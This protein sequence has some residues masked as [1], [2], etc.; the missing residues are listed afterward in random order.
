MLAEAGVLFEEGV[1]EQR[2]P[3]ALRVLGLQVGYAGVGLL[4]L[5]LS[6]VEQEQVVPHLVHLA[7]VGVTV[8]QPQQ[9]LLRQ[10]QIVELVF[11]DDAGVE[12]SVGDD[13]IALDLL[14]FGEGY[15]CQVVLAGVRVVGVGGGVG[16][17][18]RRCARG[19]TVLQGLGD[20]CPIQVLGAVGGV[21]TAHQVDH[22]LV[23]PLPVVN[24]LALAP[25]LLELLLSLA[26]GRLVVEVPLGVLATGSRGGGGR[27]LRGA[28]ADGALALL[29]L[30]YLRFLCASLLFFLFLLQFVDD[31]VDGRQPFLFGHGCQLLQRVLQI[32]GVSVGHQFVEHL[33]AVRQFLVVRALF[34]Q[35]SDGF[36]IAALRVVVF[37]L[38]P[39]EIAELQQQHAFFNAAARGFLV[40]FLVGANGA[41]RV[42]LHEVDVAHGVV[43]LVQVVLVV[44]VGSHAPQLPDHLGTVAL[45]HHFRLCYAGV[46]VQLVGR[47]LCTHFSVGPV[48]LLFVA[49]RGL[50]LSQQEVFACLLRLPLLVSDDFPEVGQGLLVLSVLDVIV[51]IGGIPVAHAVV[52]YGVAAHVAND[53]LGVVEPAQ[54]RIALGQ[55]G[56]GQRILHGLRLVEPGHVAEGGGGL[57]EIAFLELCLA[58]QQPRLPQE[59]VVLLAPEPFPVAGRLPSAF[60]PLGAALDGVQLDGLLHLFHGQAELSFAYVAA[61]LV[62]NGVEGNHLGVV[63]LVALLFLQ[64]AFDESLRAVEVGVVAGGERLP[65][66]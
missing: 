38:Y 35:Q 21:L 32:D 3:L 28:V 66:A 10:L 43:D 54:L 62:A 41:G 25:L 26:D 51:G 15:L 64:R 63:V 12:Q 53:V 61:L 6:G 34:V 52:V 36:A 30:L 14:L 18:S 37:F 17:G 31:A 47:V 2:C 22:G 50:Y 48:G 11:E 44:V 20:V 45:G 42:F 59:G 57:V 56:P 5:A 29:R 65:E 9:L 1:A 49:E 19:Q 27:A 55:P 39:V 24:V 13:V 23:G 46:E 7:E 58:H 8:R 33:R 60:V 4:G 16:R 40:A